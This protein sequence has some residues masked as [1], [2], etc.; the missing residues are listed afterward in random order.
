MNGRIEKM[1]N[2]TNARV[3]NVQKK[4]FERKA[5]KKAINAGRRRAA[6]TVTTPAAMKTATTGQ[7]NDPS[8][9]SRIANNA[10]SATTNAAAQIRGAAP[11]LTRPES[12]RGDLGLGRRVIGG[13]LTATTV[14][15]SVTIRIS[16]TT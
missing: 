7:N 6:R 5:W 8:G 16:A 4:S 1:P 9:A 14:I 15:T 11:I 10:M 3:A 12:S 2:V 13:S